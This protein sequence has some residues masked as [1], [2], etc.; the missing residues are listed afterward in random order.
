VG[1]DIPV[2]AGVGRLLPHRSAARLAAVRGVDAAF[3]ARVRRHARGLLQGTFPWH[4]FRAALL[5]DIG[6]PDCRRGHVRYA[7]NYARVHGRLLQ[8]GE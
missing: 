7:I 8:M 5:L 3:G 1:S 4:H 2:R 6:L